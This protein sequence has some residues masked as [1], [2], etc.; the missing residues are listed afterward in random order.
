[1]APGGQL[2]LATP[3]DWSP[4]ATAVEGWLGGH[5][6]RGGNRG[7]AEPVLRRLLSSAGLDIIAERQRQPWRVRLHDRAVVEYETHLVVARKPV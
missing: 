1:M 4:A 6:Q 3:W 7:A 5:S 2:I